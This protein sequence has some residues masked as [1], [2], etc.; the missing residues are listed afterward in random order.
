[1]E[2]NWAPFVIGDHLFAHRWLDDPS[3]DSQVLEIDAMNGNVVNSSVCPGAGA[4]LRSAL[5]LTDADYAV[6]LSGGTNAERLEDGSYVGIG[7]SMRDFGS[8]RRVY[9]MFGYVFDG[10]CERAL[11]R[12]GVYTQFV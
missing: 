4:A 2:K 3:G 7:H 11:R 6:K 10:Q 9:A 12:L 8:D 5:G 1:M